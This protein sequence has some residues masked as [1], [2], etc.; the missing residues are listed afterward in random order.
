MVVCLYTGL[1]IYGGGTV[2]MGS[3][4]GIYIER[5]RVGLYWRCNNF[6]FNIVN[7]YIYRSGHLSIPHLSLMGGGGRCNNSI[8]G[9]H[10]SC[11]N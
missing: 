1:L 9:G 6:E 11:S 2:M 8:Y 3:N 5:E 4:Y 10:G 7:I